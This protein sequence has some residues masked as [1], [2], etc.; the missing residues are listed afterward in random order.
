M[1]HY[2]TSVWNVNQHL[3]NLNK[4]S[5]RQD[6]EAFNF[7]FVI[8]LTIFSAAAMGLAAILFGNT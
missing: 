2:D 5:K 4:P 3:I 8:P 6:E 7:N 1:D